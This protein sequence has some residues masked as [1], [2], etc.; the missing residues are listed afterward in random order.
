MR[1]SCQTG[2]SGW[3]GASGGE[4]LEERACSELPAL[5]CYLAM[6]LRAVPNLERALGFAAGQMR[7]ETGKFL[8]RMMCELELGYRTC[9][10]EVLE[11]MVGR[12]GGRCPEVERSLHL[13]RSSVEEG[14]LASRER[15]LSMA[16]SAV[17]DGAVGR[18][19]DYALRVHHSILL[20]YTLGVLLP[21]V[22]VVMVPVISSTG[23]GGPAV[24]FFAC[25]LCPL[26]VW[27]L[28]CRALRGRPLLFEQVRIPLD[29][30]GAGTVAAA[31][32]IP[33]A[34]LAGAFVI[35]GDEG[36]PLALLLSAAV[37]ASMVLR[38]VSSG[39]YRIWQESLRMEEELPRYLVGVGNRMLEGRPA[40]EAILHAAESSGDGPL[41]RVFTS[42]VSKVRFGGMS[43]RAA[44]LGEGGAISSVHS[45]MVAGSL[46]AL[47]DLVEMGAE[48]GGEALLYISELVGRMREAGSEMRRMMGE[49][50]GSM[51]S[52]GTVFA[53]MIAGVTASIFSWLSGSEALGMF[54]WA[55]L[56]PQVF[57]LSMGFYAVVLGAVLM[58]LAAEIEF[59]ESL[60]PKV[61]S[62]ASGM[63]VAALV[64][65]V[66]FLLGS[67]FMGRIIG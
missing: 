1:I 37:P 60:P 43:L 8:R 4:G 18:A 7:G 54:G 22:L 46:R 24:L 40:E 55:V 62:L 35:P 49:M 23:F 51:R 48:A 2:G 3:R 13:I 16:L 10:A 52:V 50:V 19:R 12:W 9:G 41:R 61:M 32:V 29:P 5:V 26:M 28:G 38:S 17:L 59:G 30:P 63:P 42:V 57:V 34:F 45:G 53:P 66:S 6:A 44:L 56:S 47:S 11:E 33:L 20:V 25:V 21:L 39:P 65:T 31:A 67:Q 27:W 36:L 14:S 58:W 15:T 64:F